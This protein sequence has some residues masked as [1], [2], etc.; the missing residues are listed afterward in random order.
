MKSF[1]PKTSKSVTS[2]ALLFVFLSFL[3][4]F[5]VQSTKAEDPHTE[6]VWV[7]TE[8]QVNPYDGQ[9]EFYGGRGGW[10]GEARFEGTFVKY[11]VTETSFRI[12]DRW[13]D[14]EYEYHNVT[15]ET[16]FEKPPLK[17]TPGETIEL[18]YGFSHSG[19]E[20]DGGIGV[21]FWY[22]SED[23]DIQP[24]TVFRYSP[25]A[26]GFDGTTDG[27]YSFEVPSASSGSEIEIYAGWWNAE[28]CQVIWKYQAQEVSGA[29]DEEVAPDQVEEPV[30]DDPVQ[31]VGQGRELGEA[32]CA[33][34]QQEVAEQAGIGGLSNE[35][36][37]K[38]GII[39]QVVNQHGSA[40]HDYC[41]GGEGNL[42]E[43]GLIKIGDCIRTGSD[44]DLFIQMNDQNDDINAGPSIIL[45]AA[46]S[47]MCFDEFYVFANPVRRTTLISLI[48]GALRAITKGWQ[49]GSTF[50]VKAG[51]TIC[52]GRGTEFFIQY[53]PDFDFVQA[54][55]I[56]GHMDVT[57]EA[58]G[59]TVSLYDNQKLVVDEG[60]II[61]T[62]HVSQELWDLYLE[63]YGLRDA[64]F[65]DVEIVDGEIIDEESLN[66]GN[67][68]DGNTYEPGSQS[69][70]PPITLVL[71]LCVVLLCVVVLVAIIVGI[72]YFVRNRSKP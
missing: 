51:T 29:A 46:D 9:L 1:I 14:H 42:S 59:E 34:M 63:E 11:A 16:Y 49:N 39:G 57:S 12:E 27:T 60:D 30:L 62:G 58:T 48:K 54:L 70:S 71:I 18:I 7:L 3:L 65:P 40:V 53:N 2:I 33:R 56:E 10:F 35:S 28:P 20:E 69:Q 24:D 41:T 61:D 45:V 8:T 31:E 22:D 66:V 36:D 43:G 15:I 72:V 17:L 47:E 64:D 37:L 6:M 52:G 4:V 13:V 21:M 25:W 68:D 26:E 67:V 32:E 50:N 55:V 38:L 5:Q 19:T 23:V 44:G